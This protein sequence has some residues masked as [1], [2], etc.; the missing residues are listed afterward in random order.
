VRPLLTA[1]RDNLADV[2]R[3]APLAPATIRQAVLPVALVEP[4]LRSLEGLG[5]KIALEQ[6][7]ISPLSRVWRI[8]IAKVRQ[9]F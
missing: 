1:A 9:R 6:A 5:S 8:F 2:R 7:E 4:Y 3:C